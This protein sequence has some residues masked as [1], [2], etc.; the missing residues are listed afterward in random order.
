MGVKIKV[1]DYIK[2]RTIAEA[3]HIIQTGATIR[4][5][6]KFFCV[7]KSTVHKDMHERLKEYDWLMYT[8]VQRV[9]QVNFEA[10]H[11]RGGISTKIKYDMIK[12]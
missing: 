7:S 1:K 5:T 2:A 4:E 12:A 3:I 8:K 6:A 10:K 11:I 9:L